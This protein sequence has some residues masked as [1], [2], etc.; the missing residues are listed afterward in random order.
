[1]KVRKADGTRLDGRADYDVALAMDVMHHIDADRQQ[2]AAGGLAR[3]LRPGGVCLVKDIATTPTWQ[4]GWNLLH[5]R[6]VAGSEPIACR[7]P[8]EMAALF[9]SVGLE[10]ESARRLSRYSPYPH[11]LLRL[12][13]PASELGPARRLT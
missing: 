10:T 7:S 5:D 6:L 2:L 4:Y 9:A 3:S 1:V 8:G 13:K 11:Y 12:R